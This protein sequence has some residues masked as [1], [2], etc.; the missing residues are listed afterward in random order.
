M[1]KTVSHFTLQI[2]GINGFTYLLAGAILF[3]S[4][5]NAINGPGWLGNNMGIPGTG[6]FTEQS[7]SLPDTLDLSRSE[8]RLK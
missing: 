6:T 7:N 5:M 2:L 8:F 4:A 3:F 1:E